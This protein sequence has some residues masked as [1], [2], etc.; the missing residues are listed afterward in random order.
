MIDVSSG[1][2][3]SG[4][5]WGDKVSIWLMFQVL[6][7]HQILF[8]EIKTRYDWH[9]KYFSLTRFYLGR[10]NLFQVLFPH[11]ILFQRTKPRCNCCFKC[12]SFIRYY[13]GRQNL[14]VIDISS[15]FPLSDFIWEYKTSIPLMFQVLFPHQILGRQNLDITDVSS[16]FHLQI[17]GRQNFS[18]IDVSSSFPSSDF[19]W[20]DET[21]FKYF[22][23]IRFFLERQNL[24]MIDISSTFPSSDFGEAKPRYNWCFKYFSSSDFEEG[25]TSI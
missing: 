7:L 5:I 24:N 14:N 18:L 23:L 10:Q 15:S 20:G 17:M 9:F 25:K 13:L 1:F 8:G 6:F 19:I 21:C 11:Q 4:F 2:P 16:T 3:S 12:F 22:S